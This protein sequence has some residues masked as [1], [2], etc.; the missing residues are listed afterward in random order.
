VGLYN[1]QLLGCGVFNDV[2]S[3]P[4]QLNWSKVG[5]G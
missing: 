4:I 3:E 5:E 1:D 2:T